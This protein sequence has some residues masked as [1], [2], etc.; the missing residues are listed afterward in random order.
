M[1]GAWRTH[2]KVAHIVQERKRTRGWVR[3]GW[4][5]KTRLHS[6]PWERMVAV[7]VRAMAGGTVPTAPW[8]CSGRRG[9]AGAF[10]G[11]CREETGS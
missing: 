5:R 10:R 9:R 11:V 4:L 3:E 8:R 2:D 1:L 6:F 7:P